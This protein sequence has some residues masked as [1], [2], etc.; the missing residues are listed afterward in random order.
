MPGIMFL[1]LLEPFQHQ[2]RLLIPDLRGHGNSM[3]LDE[4]LSMRD[5]AR[6]LELLLQENQL[7]QADVLGYSMGGAVAQTLA[8][9]APAAV[10]R[11]VLCCTFAH[12]Q[13]TLAER[14]A[15]QLGKPVLRMA[16]PRGVASVINPSVT[17][18]PELQAHIVQWLRHSIRENNRTEHLVA[19]AEAIFQFDA[20]P[21]LPGL[22]QPALVLAGDQDP[23]VRPVHAHR[24]KRLLPN[25]RLHMMPGANHAF[26]YS[27]T[28]MMA[29][30]IHYFLEETVPWV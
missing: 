22:E 10:R 7:A 9:T 6:D 13:L 27:H 28:E 18:N 15:P 23:V 17:E 12:K 8:I 30:A 1:P 21:H 11:L 16:G 25:A 29:A 4:A 26:I 24:L 3:G 19:G 5:Y 14:L 20:R 2:Y